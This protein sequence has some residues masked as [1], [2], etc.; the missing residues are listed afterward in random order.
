[1]EHFVYIFHIFVFFAFQRAD[2]NERKFSG[3]R[4]RRVLSQQR[5]VAENLKDVYKETLW[6]I[7]R[8]NRLLYGLVGWCQPSLSLI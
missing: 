2:K 1:M 7:C 3:F 6:P 5:N 8:Q 4:L